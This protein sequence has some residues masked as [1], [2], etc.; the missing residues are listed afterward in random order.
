MC[1]RGVRGVR[2][3]VCVCVCV[4]VRVWVCMYI[5]VCNTCVS[6]ASGNESV[7]D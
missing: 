6:M 3:C 2:V 4:C 7:S 1:V 5:H